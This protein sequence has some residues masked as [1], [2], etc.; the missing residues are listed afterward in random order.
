LA[1][2]SNKEDKET[3]RTRAEV[4]LSK[5]K[6]ELEKRKSTKN[7]LAHPESLIKP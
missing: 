7:R 6:I 5:Q 3:K 4:V 1:E 2:K